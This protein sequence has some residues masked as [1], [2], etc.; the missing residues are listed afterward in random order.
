LVA[1][2]WPRLVGA[3]LLFKKSMTKGIYSGT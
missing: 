2:C 1:G 3:R